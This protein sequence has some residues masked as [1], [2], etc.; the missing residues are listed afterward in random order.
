MLV[1]LLSAILLGGVQS[2]ACTMHGLGAGLAATATETGHVAPGVSP[3]SH[4]SDRHSHGTDDLGCHC[5]CIGDCSMAAPLALTPAAIT[6]RVALVEPEPRRPLDLEPAHAPTAEPDRLLPFANGP[7][8]P[9][10][11]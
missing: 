6:L 9:A 3:S 2:A 1:A 10:L 7:P 8:A 5:T 11:T 4:G